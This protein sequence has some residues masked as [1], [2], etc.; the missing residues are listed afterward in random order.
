MLNVLQ[1]CHSLSYHSLLEMTIGLRIAALYLVSIIH[2]YSAQNNIQQLAIFRQFHLFV[3]TK[4]H[5]S[6]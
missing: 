4:L 6:D 1:H 5:L 3:Q 2:E